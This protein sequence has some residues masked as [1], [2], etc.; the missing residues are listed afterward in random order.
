MRDCGFVG[1]CLN[2]VVALLLNSFFV[3]ML[4]DLTNFFSFFFLL[5]ED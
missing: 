4:L 3:A 1:L 5:L 2:S